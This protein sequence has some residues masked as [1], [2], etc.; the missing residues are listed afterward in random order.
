MRKAN[1][2][3]EELVCRTG[4]NPCCF[5]LFAMDTAMKTGEPNEIDPLQNQE[6][7]NR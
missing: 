1:C 7:S 5:R 6:S 4:V 2:G 3:F